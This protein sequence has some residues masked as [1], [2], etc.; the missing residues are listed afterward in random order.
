MWHPSKALIKP[1][2]GFHPPVHPVIRIVTLCVLVVAVCFVA[3]IVVRI[4][5]IRR[6]CPLSTRDEPPARA[7]LS[8]P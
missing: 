5:I 6:V 1:R 8:G 2:L 7:V 3:I 4:A